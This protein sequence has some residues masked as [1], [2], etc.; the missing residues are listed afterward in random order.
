[1]LAPA[2]VAEIRRLLGEGRLS[3]RAIAR[4]LG[5]SRGIVHAIANGKRRER[6]APGRLPPRLLVDEGP[7]ERC[8]G[9]GGIVQMPCL[10]CRMR[11]MRQQRRLTSCG[12]G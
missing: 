12:S 2:I 3:Q 1:M 10:L 6:V 7:W 4:H 9:C 8:P 5:V 11:A